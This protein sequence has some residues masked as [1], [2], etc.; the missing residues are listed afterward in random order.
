MATYNYITL[1]AALQ[2]IANRLFDPTMTFWVSAELTLYLQEALRTFNAL[3]SYWRNDFLFPTVANATWYDLRTVPN[4]IRP[5]TL[6]DAN[7]YTLIEYHLLEPAPATN[8]I[9]PWTGSKQFTAA[10][11]LAAVERRQNELLSITGCTQT[12]S[13]VPAVAGR[14][15]LPQ[16][17]IDVRRMAYIPSTLFP[18]QAASV[19]WPEDT[20][21]EMSFN[22]RYIQSPAGTPLTYL[23]STQPPIAFDT[24]VPPAYAGNYELLTVTAIN[25]LSASTPTLLS[26]PDDWSHVLKWGALADLFSREWESKDILRATYCEQRYRLGLAAMRKAPALLAM[27]LNNVPLQIDSVRAGD[28]YNTGWEGLA[29]GTPSMCFHSGLNLIALA[30]AA[31]STAFSLTAT[32][33]QNAPIPVNPTDPV[34]VSRDDLDAIIDYC[35]HIATLKMGGSEFSQTQPLLQRFLKQCAMHNGK[36][37]EMAEYTAMLADLSQREDDMNPVMTPDGEQAAT[38]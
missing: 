12:Q 25:A 28:L 2:Q 33:V 34:Q 36:L 18:S 7:L 3:T 9:N 26:L 21:G 16:N 27:R 1:S 8:P 10:D 23:L 11:L 22:S 17:T 15:Q 13:T 35:Q 37:M 29:A 4:T 14:I 30:A 32:V 5:I 6:T 24:D 31:S 19:M 38:S 20:W